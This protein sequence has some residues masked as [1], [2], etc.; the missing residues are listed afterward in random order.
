MID[1]ERE[2]FVHIYIPNQ[3]MSC[4]HHEIGEQIAA[5][6]RAIRAKEFSYRRE[7]GDLANGRT[8]NVVKRR[9]GVTK[10]ETRGQASHIERASRRKHAPSE[11]GTR[12]GIASNTKVLEFEVFGSANFPR[13]LREVFSQ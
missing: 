1:N 10:F 2:P 12:I 4:F 11:L 6:Q 8:R 3:A 13:A 5:R 9:G 7:K